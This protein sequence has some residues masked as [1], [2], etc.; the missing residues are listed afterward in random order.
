VRSLAWRSRLRARGRR[1][2][3]GSGRGSEM[4]GADGARNWRG[5]VAEVADSGGQRSSGEV[6]ERRKRTGM[7]VR[8][9][10]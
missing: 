8:T 2:K 7:R 1:K 9:R 5:G 4:R 3:S 10:E 6:V